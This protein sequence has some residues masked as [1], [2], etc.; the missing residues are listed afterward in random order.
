MLSPTGPS[1]KATGRVVRFA[2]VVRERLEPEPR[3]THP[4]LIDPEEHE[5]SALMARLP[6]VASCHVVEIGCGDGRLTRRYCTRV[7]TV[8]AID[9]DD[10]LI[11]AFRAGGVDANVD[12]RAASVEAL[13]LPEASADAVLFSWA[14]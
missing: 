4:V 9:P 13:D 12:L 11:S 3:Y 10:S 1:E 14:L 6:S 2:T 5:L 7:A 8:L